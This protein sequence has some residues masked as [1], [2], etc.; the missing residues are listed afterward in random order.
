MKN[1]YKV[2]GIE[3]FSSIEVVKARFIFLT[4]AYHPD[5]FPDLIYKNEAQEEFIKIKEAYDTLGNEKRKNEYDFR[6]REELSFVKNRSYSDF[7]RPDYKK[8]STSGNGEYRR[9]YY[10]NHDSKEK[11]EGSFGNNFFR[12]FIAFGFLYFLIIAFS[13]LASQSSALNT[14]TPTKSKNS[15]IMPTATISILSEK[16]NALLTAGNFSNYFQEGDERSKNYLDNSSDNFFDMVDIID[17]TIHD[18]KK[19]GNYLRIYDLEIEEFNYPYAIV[20]GYLENRGVVW[21]KYYY[22]VYLFCNGS[23]WKVYSIFIE[24]T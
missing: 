5:K 13:N 17:T 14:T 16:S 10:G 11:R 19:W 9:D 20:S 22:K 6:L 21:L 12:I 24:K 18:V 2:L 23:Q 3:N 15:I 4:H 7:S 8:Y 1:F